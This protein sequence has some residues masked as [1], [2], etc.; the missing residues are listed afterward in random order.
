MSHTI[1][2][3]AGIVGVSAAIWLRRAGQRVTLID[4]SGP[5]AGTSYGNGGV[6]ASCSIVPVTGP[7]LIAKAPKMALDPNQPLFVRWPYV[8]R[9]APWLFKY[10]HHANKADTT[11]IAKALTPIV[12]DSLA[13]HQALAAG[14]GAERYIAPSDYLFI[15][16]ARQHYEGDAFSWHLR[17]ANGFTW[18]ELEGPAFKAYDPAFAD[19]LTFAAKLENHGRI[20]DPGAYV[21]ALS[22]HFE[23]QGGTFLKADVTDIT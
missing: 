18:E 5:A 23:A 14:T 6:L 4:K 10:L 3:G 20:T 7:G 11:R 12:G 2:I 22:A 13:D 21:N 17:R 19:H 1:I 15:Y 8:P 9:L 16:N